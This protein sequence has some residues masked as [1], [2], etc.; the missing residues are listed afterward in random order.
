MT[1]VYE[2]NSNLEIWV[3]RFL[4]VRPGGFGD[5]SKGKGGIGQQ[6]RILAL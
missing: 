6:G 1:T 4:E 2:R 3:T 5:G